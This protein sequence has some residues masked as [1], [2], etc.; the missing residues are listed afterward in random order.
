M[1][2]IEKNPNKKNVSFLEKISVE[3]VKNHITMSGCKKCYWFITDDEKED[4]RINICKL[5]QKNTILMHH[6]KLISDEVEE[7]E[8]EH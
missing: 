1:R 2:N 7:N 8:K 5:H 3:H 4:I 6:L